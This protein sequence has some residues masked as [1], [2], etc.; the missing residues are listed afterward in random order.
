M[1]M[2]V[3]LRKVAHFINTSMG[4]CLQAVCQAVP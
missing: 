4:L 2:S 3:F 1:V